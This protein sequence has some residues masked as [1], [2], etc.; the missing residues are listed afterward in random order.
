MPDETLELQ[1]FE[2]AGNRFALFD[3]R[4]LGSPSD[5]ARLARESCVRDA[6]RAGWCADGL[7]VLTRGEDGA[8][9]RMA[10]YNAD[11]SR[12]EACG[13]G[14][15]S[16]AWYLQLQLEREEFTIETDA[17][18]RRTSFVV[19]DGDAARVRT[20]MGPAVARDLSSP[21][22]PPLDAL[23]ATFVEVGNPHCVLEVDDEGALDLQRLA[24]VVERHPDYPK[25]VNVSVV[26]RRLDA[27][28][29]RVHERGVGE[30]EACGTGACAV[31]TALV[32]HGR[33]SFPLELH[34]PGD[35]LVV[36]GDPEQGLQLVGPVK[37]VG[38][39]ELALRS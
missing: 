33:A 34:L 27:W 22:P 31:A 32:R 36:E 12:A 15:R 4:L 14:L 5:P 25:G 24:R 13:N 10:I 6:L 28:H 30:T 21:L 38:R 11:G 7:L 1:L 20:D 19:Q 35:V 26:A 17:G 29:V 37:C 39:V 18:A 2:A 9:G 3:G 23:P 16:I 8:D